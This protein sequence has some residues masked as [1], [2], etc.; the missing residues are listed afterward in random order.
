[1]CHTKYVVEDPVAPVGGA[2]EQASTVLSQHRQ[3]LCDVAVK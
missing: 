1:M 2:K 3:G